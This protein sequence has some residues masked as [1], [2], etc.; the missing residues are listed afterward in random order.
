MTIGT[1][2]KKCRTAQGLTQEDLAHQP[3]GSHLPHRTK[4][5]PLTSQR[6]CSDWF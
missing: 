5:A 3:I 2:L 6:R 4:T 1:H